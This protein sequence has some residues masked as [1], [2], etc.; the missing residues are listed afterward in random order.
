MLASGIDSM[1]M[2]T[3]Q[4]TPMSDFS[5]IK[6]ACDKQG[7]TVV[8]NKKKARKMKMSAETKKKKSKESMKNIR[9]KDKYEEKEKSL[10]RDNDEKNSKKI[11]LDKLFKEQG[12]KNKLQN[13]KIKAKEQNK[14]HI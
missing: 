9:K 14:I 11:E 12:I 10:E 4:P 1:M 2:T 6:Q 7:F 3:N 8:I 5:E 13:Y